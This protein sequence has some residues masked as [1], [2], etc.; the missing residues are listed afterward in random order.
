MLTFFFSSLFSS[1][2]HATFVPIR[3]L[4]IIRIIPGLMTWVKLL[5][6]TSSK[7]LLPRQSLFTFGKVQ[8]SWSCSQTQLKIPQG[9]GFCHFLKHYVMNV[10]QLVCYGGVPW[11][12]LRLPQSLKFLVTSSVFYVT[13]I[14]E[15]MELPLKN[16]GH[17][18]GFGIDFKL[19]SFLSYC[20]AYLFH[21]VNLF[22]FSFFATA[23]QMAR[24]PLHQHHEA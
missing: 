17:S 24:M 6:Q 11:A 22:T 7:N 20:W 5:S 21:F 23:N 2:H 15:S 8:L 13:K 12:Y 16:A 10:L 3:R 14:I 1:C 4:K 18:Y 19:I 9:T